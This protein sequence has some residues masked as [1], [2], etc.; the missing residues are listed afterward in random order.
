MSRRVPVGIAARAS[1]QTER[2]VR[3]YL[4]S[5]TIR[6]LPVTVLPAQVAALGEDFHREVAAPLASDLSIHL[7]F[8]SPHALATFDPHVRD[9]CRV[10][11]MELL[12]IF[13]DNLIDELRTII[14]PDEVDSWMETPNTR[15][16]GRKP[17]E[18]LGTPDDRPLRDFILAVRH[19]MVS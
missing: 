19:G 6:G 7:E 16:G 3:L 12:G 8:V 18:F 10:Q 14:R 15:F 17:K 1:N 13:A 5:P 11:R 2:H 9:V 4:P